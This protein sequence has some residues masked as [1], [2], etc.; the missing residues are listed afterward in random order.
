MVNAVDAL[1]QAFERQGPLVAAMLAQRAHDLAAVADAGPDPVTADD[2]V[3]VLTLR[4]PTGRWALAV[5]EVAR[6]EPLADIVALPGLPP[7]VLGLALLGGRRCLVVDP[8]VVVAAAACRPIGRP[9]HAV[10][11]R[12]HPL[13]LAV[14]RA[15]AVVR[16]PPPARG[17]QVL[18]DGSLLMEAGRLVAAATRGGVP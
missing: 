3:L 8:G 1:R 9:G 16:L 10:V 7:P 4:G 13:A 17:G 6:V 15:E 18:A 14:D 11:L 12:H 5:A 2:H